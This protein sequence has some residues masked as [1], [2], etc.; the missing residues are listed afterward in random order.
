M[1]QQ[2]QL[3]ANNHKRLSNSAPKERDSNNLVNNLVHSQ[4]RLAVF[5][6]IPNVAS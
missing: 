1:G 2:V 6:S 3:L 5:A 4:V